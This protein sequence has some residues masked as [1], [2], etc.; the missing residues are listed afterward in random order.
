MMIS[1]GKPFQKP[2]LRSEHFLRIFSENDL[3]LK[4]PTFGGTAAAA[5]ATTT[6]AAEEFPNISH[7]HPI[8]HRDEISRSGQT[9]TPII[10]TIII[11][12]TAAGAV[13]QEF[14]YIVLASQT[15]NFPQLFK[16]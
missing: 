6:T 8:T 7:P 4:T 15:I 13:D 5:A 1:V 3:F 16:V 11:I 14:V 9:L 12:I 2:G 10:I